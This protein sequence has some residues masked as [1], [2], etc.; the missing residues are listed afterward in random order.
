MASVP[1]GDASLARLLDPASIAIVGASD[2][3]DKIGGRPIHYMRRHGYAGTLYPINPQRAEV[4]GERAWPSLAALP[5]APDLAIVAVAGE[6]AVRAVDDCA[7]LGVA[8]AIVISA[9]FSETGEAGRALQ[10]AM[11]ARAR[12]AGM[13]IVGPNSQG[14]ANFGNG[15]IASFSTMFLE[16][17]PGDGPVAV[18]SQSGGMCAMVYGLLRQRG[19]GVR[20]VHATGNEAD[21][22]VA[23]LACATLRDP[24]VGCVLL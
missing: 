1:T 17:T 4:Q 20:H 16:V 5:V 13:R 22:S 12:A 6:Q 3:P 21:V 10:D 9:G 7:A 15:A 23:E 18:I 2:N 24:E 19:I 11:T 14:L 8:A